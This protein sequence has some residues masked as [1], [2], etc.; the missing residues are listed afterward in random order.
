M[1]CGS[2]APRLKYCHEYKT[3]V[4]TGIDIYLKFL[5]HTIF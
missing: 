5:Q 2:E 4:M 3:V 1:S